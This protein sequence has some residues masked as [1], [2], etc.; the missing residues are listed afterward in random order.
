VLCVALAAISIDETV[1]NVALPTLSWEL[2]TSATQLQWIVE[3]YVL[4]IGALVLT[5]GAL[6]DRY[7]RR[8]GLVLGLVVFG[9]ASAAGAFAPSANLLIAARVVMGIG[10]AMIMPSTLS[11]VRTSFPE[12]ERRLALGVW[13][14]VLGLG[15][16]VGPLIGGFLLEHFWWGSVFLLALPVMALLLVLGPRVLPEYRDPEAGRLDLVSAAMSVAAILAVIYGL[17]QIAQD[18]MSAGPAL[19]ILAGLVIAV[20][21]VRR[22]RRLADPM[23]DVGLFRIT[24][25]NAALATNF[26]AIFVAVGYF[27][28]IAQYLQLVVGLSPFEAGLWSLPAAFGFIV[29]SQFGPRIVGKFRPAFVIAGGLALTAAGLA[30]LTQV[31]TSD[32]LVPLVAASLLISLGLA[33]VFGLTTEL[34]VGSARPEQ[35][36][37]ASGISETGAELGGALGIAILGS[38]GIAIYR[39]E[40]ADRLPAAVPDGAAAIARD[41]LGS[42][43]EVAGELPD[44]LGAAV[45]Q[46]AREAFVNGMQLSSAIAAVVAVGLAILALAMLRHHPTVSAEAPAGGD[47]DQA[48]IGDRELATADSGCA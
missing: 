33:P 9:A 17:K 48:A 23:I 10:A 16:L 39:A 2:S 44:R 20:V 25:F 42:A 24:A 1:I 38:V 21:F 34:I 27:L 13:T 4:V 8:L 19:I 46:T 37:A 14:A 47:G 36:G 40:V 5:A 45:I 6:S 43:V 32:G 15:I 12:E 30:V 35:A 26:L 41:T 29:G 3:S 22:Q 7:G 11:I 18:G 31:G 28:F